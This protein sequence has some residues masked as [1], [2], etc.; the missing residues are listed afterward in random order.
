[1]HSA[2]TVPRKSSRSDVSSPIIAWY[3]IPRMSSSDHTTSGQL[4]LLL[5]SSNSGSSGHYFPLTANSQL[6]HWLSKS[7]VMLWP[8]VSRP[9]CLGVKPNL[10]PRTRFLLMS[11]SCRFIDVRHPL[12]RENGSFVYSCFWT[13]PAQSYSGLIPAGLMTI[14]Y[15]LTFETPP[16]RRPG[17]FTY[18][19]QEQDDPIIPPR[20]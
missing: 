19:H 2:N 6:S 11:H 9:I 20:H 8:T 10:G 16:T 3:W 13:L 18:F 1:M 4:T 5:V 7:K 15:C 17:P 12:W 14:F